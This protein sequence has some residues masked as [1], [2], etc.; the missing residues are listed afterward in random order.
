M[1]F[2]IAFVNILAYDFKW[3]MRS[4]VLQYPFLFL[5]VV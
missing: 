2:A 4:K 3:L 1:Y 5:G